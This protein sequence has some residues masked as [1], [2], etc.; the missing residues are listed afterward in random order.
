MTS[1]LTHTVEGLELPAPGL[2]QI[3]PAHSGVDF[4][5][6]HLG[7]SKVRGRFGVFSGALTIAEAPEQSSVAVSIEVESIDTREPTRDTHLRSPDFFDAATHPTIEFTSRSVTGAG[8]QWEVEGDLTIKGVSRP[9]VLEVT[10]EG[11]ATD[12]WGGSRVAFSG[13]TEIDREDW[14][15]TYNQ[16]LE[17]GGWLVGKKVKIELELEAVRQDS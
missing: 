6:R 5:V 12:P 17:A 10:Y 11:A 1:A 4:Q 8:S 15:M 2:W 13:S 9:V 16:A 14:G 3:D 7:L